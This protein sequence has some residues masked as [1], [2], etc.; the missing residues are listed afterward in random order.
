MLA[1]VDNVVRSK[2]NSSFPNFKKQSRYPEMGSAWTIERFLAVRQK[3]AFLGN[4]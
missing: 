1:I 4:L 3:Q 2:G